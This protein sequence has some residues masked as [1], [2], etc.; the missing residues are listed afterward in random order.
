MCCWWGLMTSSPRHIPAREAGVQAQPRRQ[1]AQEQPATAGLRS[2][3]THPSQALEVAILTHH[4][5]PEPTNTT[6]LKSNTTK[7]ASAPAFLTSPEARASPLWSHLSSR[8][9]YTPLCAAWRSLVENTVLSFLT[10]RHERV[11]GGADHV[12]AGPDAPPPTRSP[13]LGTMFLTMKASQEPGVKTS[14]QGWR[15]SLAEESLGCHFCRALDSLLRM[16]E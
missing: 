10:E 2:V 15:M 4:F 7:H 13:S 14:F 8:H 3:S 6:S 1:A 11:L 12:T 9:V 16:G 5:P